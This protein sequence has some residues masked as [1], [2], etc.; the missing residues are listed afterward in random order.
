MLAHRIA[1]VYWFRA[2]ESASHEVYVS[3]ACH[4]ATCSTWGPM[5][6]DERQSENLDRLQLQH[7]G[8]S[9]W[10]GTP[11]WVRPDWM[12]PAVGTDWELSQHPSILS[13]NM[14]SQ[15]RWRKSRLGA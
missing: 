4:A 7:L 11:A 2:K 8:R 9:L 12:F 14:R 1:A 6:S 10:Y 3:W 13:R 15:H 5:Y